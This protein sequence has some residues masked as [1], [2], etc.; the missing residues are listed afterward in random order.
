MRELMPSN[1]DDSPVS[2]PLTEVFQLR[3]K[4]AEAAPTS[5]P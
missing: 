2:R 1:P 3:V 4:A 5:K